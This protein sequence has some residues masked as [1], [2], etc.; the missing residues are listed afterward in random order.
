[1]GGLPNFLY[2][3]IR[4]V[5]M[6]QQNGP[7]EAR[8]EPR[9]ELFSVDVSIPAAVLSRCLRDTVPMGSGHG[10]RG[11]LRNPASVTPSWALDGQW[12]V[13]SLPR[14]AVGHC[15]PSRPCHLITVGHSTTLSLHNYRPPPRWPPPKS[16]AFVPLYLQ[17]AGQLLVYRRSS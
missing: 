13:L 12:V 16:A 15:R 7:T 4:P 10:G 1:M 3:F 9:V 14:R 17:L 8:P 6:D 2:L 5:E 11:S